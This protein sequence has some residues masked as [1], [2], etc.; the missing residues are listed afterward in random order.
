MEDKIVTIEH[1]GLECMMFTRNGINYYNVT[2]W[3]TQ[4]N[5]NESKYKRRRIY[6]YITCPS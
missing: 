6:K 5:E 1:L 4:V 3:R 2:N